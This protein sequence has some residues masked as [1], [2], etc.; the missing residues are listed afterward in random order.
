MNNRTFHNKRSEIDVVKLRSGD[1]SAVDTCYE[2]DG[3]QAASSRT[4]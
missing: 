3:R 4:V 2:A 1:S